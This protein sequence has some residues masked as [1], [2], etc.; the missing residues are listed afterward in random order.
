V[1]SDPSLIGQWRYEEGRFIH[2]V[3]ATAIVCA[4]SRATFHGGFQLTAEYTDGSVIYSHF[5][6]LP[7]APDASSIRIEGLGSWGAKSPKSNLDWFGLGDAATI[8]SLRG[9]STIYTKM[10][11]GVEITSTYPEDFAYLRRYCGDDDVQPIIE[12]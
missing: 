3:P 7:A 1:V 6:G 11:E 12:P 9:L 8:E 5:V 10:P 4:P 2:T